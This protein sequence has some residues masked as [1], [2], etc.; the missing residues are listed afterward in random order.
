V[1]EDDMLPTNIVH[2]W[3]T[4]HIQ[5]M[6]GE[7]D[8][9]NWHSIFYNETSTVSIYC[10]VQFVEEDLKFYLLRLNAED[11]Q[12]NEFIHL[13]NISTFKYKDAS[14]VP[15]EEYDFDITD[16]EELSLIISGDTLWTKCMRYSS[17]VGQDWRVDQNLNVNDTVKLPIIENSYALY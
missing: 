6:A 13:G 15:N 11:T 14:D 1:S 8:E 3:I 12:N 10:F 17:T 16:C 7:V 9:S 5:E 4:P 2:D